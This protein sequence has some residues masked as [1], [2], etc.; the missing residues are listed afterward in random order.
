MKVLID[1]NT[2]I[3]L[4]DLHTLGGVSARLKGLLEDIQAANGQLVIPVQV[5]GEYISGAG[6][7]G[8]EL[9]GKFLR[10]RLI[11]VAS[12]D[13]VAALECAIMDR[14]A[15]ASGNKR[16]PLGREVSWQKIKIDRQI[17]AIAKVL[18]VARIISAD[19]DIPKIAKSVGIPCL[20]AEDLPLPSW[21]VQ[22]HIEEILSTPAT[23]TQ[24]DPQ[25]LRLVAAQQPSA[26]N[27]GA[28]SLGPTST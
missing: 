12:F 10:N 19:G 8:Q 7:A 14:T 23:P 6:Q 15:I 20:T 28:G 21:A 27:Q 26:Q 16:T 2:L 25:R 24:S 5:I 13:Y 22:V 9:L 1:T 4:L 3:K 11:K 18:N 17:V